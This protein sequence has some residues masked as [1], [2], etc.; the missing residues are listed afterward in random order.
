MIG[1]LTVMMQIDQE[2]ATSIMHLLIRTWVDHSTSLIRL[3]MV[4]GGWYS[5]WRFPKSLYGAYWLFSYTENGL[6]SL[7]LKNGKFSD[8][9]VFQN[10]KGS[11][12]QFITAKSMI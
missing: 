11:R 3:R 7:I 8:F 5:L 9:F 10:I 2:V 12:F 6:Q 1:P 4:I